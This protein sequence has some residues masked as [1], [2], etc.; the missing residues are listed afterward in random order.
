MLT[1]AS[2]AYNKTRFVDFDNNGTQLAGNEFPY[3]PRL[4]ISVGADY[5]FPNGFFVSA[6]ANYNS[7]SFN[8]VN[9]TPAD[10]LDSRWLANLRAGY[11]AENWRI[12]AFA[13][14]LF[15]ED[16]LT[17]LETGTNRAIAG[18]P[19]RFGVRAT[20]EF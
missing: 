18:D 14:N 13:E 17:R 20:Y 11:E 12:T 2:A 10:E 16:Y 8:D 7:K 5:F 3:A 1:Y 19:L 6:D 15:D 4:T 9:N